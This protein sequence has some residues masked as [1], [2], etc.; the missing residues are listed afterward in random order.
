MTAAADAWADTTAATPFNA[1]TVGGR[2]RRWRPLGSGPNAIVGTSAP[3]LVRRSRDMRR[4]NPIA[5][6]AM[7]LLA[8]HIVGAGIRPQSLCPHDKTRSALMQA[9][10]DWTKMSDADGVLDFYGQQYQAVIGMV[11]GGETFARLR[12]RLLSDGLPVPLQIQMIPAEQVPLD[13]NQPNGT[14]NVLQGIERNAIAARVAYWMY[15]QHPGDTLPIGQSV[16]LQPVRVDAADVC[17][18]YNATDDI[19]QLRG[20]PWLAA[21]MTT[22]HQVND[23][24]DAELVRKQTAA[25]MVG[26]LLQKEETELSIGDVAQ[27]GPT[28]VGADNIPDIAMEPG[29]FNVLNAGQDVKFN[30]PADV[31][32]SFDPF[33]RANYRA[34]AA[35]AG[36]LYQ[37]LTG[38]WTS[39]N[40]RTFR[41][42]FNTFKR[43]ATGWQYNLVCTQ[44]NEPVWQRFIDYAV[45]S[46]A[47]KPPKSLSDVDLR[48]VSWAPDR[49]AYI[50][51]A[52]DIA[53][54]GEELALGLNSRSAVVAE[55]GDN[56][57]TI[58][59]QIAA[60]HRR[61]QALGL[62]FNPNGQAA[63]SFPPP[64]DNSAQQPEQ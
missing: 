25:V 32:S 54:T 52:Q 10:D 59:A 24:M 38:D 15:P 20:L 33:L 40:D 51:P 57:E 34:V 50:N 17:H 47:I 45:A 42:Q 61:E 64:S 63:G 55:R 14:N 19:G 13:W 9:W 37:E 11:A 18:L 16:D 30:E 62:N 56:V 7:D 60:D 53:A 27:M 26:F 41:A 35:A 39:A 5:K 6:R 43:Q 21:A 4:N 36:V 44:F 58:D 49:W 1:A 12:T 2:F 8:A 48:R 23:Y 28:S 3:Q 22:L 29:A 31:G 46:G